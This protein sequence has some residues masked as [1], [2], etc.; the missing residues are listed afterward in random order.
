MQEEQTGSFKL[1][2]GNFGLGHLLLIGIII[3]AGYSIFGGDSSSSSST[4]SDTRDNST[5]AY[6]QAKN[7][8]SSVLKSPSTADFPFL[9]GGTSVGSNTYRVTS[10]VDS[11]NGFGA[12]IRSNYDITLEY[13]GGNA[14]DQRNWKVIDFT[15]DGEEVAGVKSEEDQFIANCLENETGDEEFCRA[16]YIAF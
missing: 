13:T 3:F 9:G 10:Y 12:M 16:L 2:K 11:Q 4:T 1:A 5:M 8:V 15:F 14:A 7:F 6:V